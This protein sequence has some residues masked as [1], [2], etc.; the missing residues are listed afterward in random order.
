LN[1]NRQI[2]KDHIIIG[3]QKKLI[4]NFKAVNNS[5]MREGLGRN[6]DG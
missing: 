2:L 1:E 3:K 4:D 6:D 5:Q